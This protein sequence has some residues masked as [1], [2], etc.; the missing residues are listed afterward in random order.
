MRG[1]HTLKS[2]FQ[3]FLRQWGINYSQQVGGSTKKGGIVDFGEKAISFI[4]TQ[5]ARKMVLP[6]YYPLLLAASAG[7]CPLF[8]AYF[9]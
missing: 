3:A 2:R 1:I 8:P 4:A 7:C 5:A 6:A 9:A